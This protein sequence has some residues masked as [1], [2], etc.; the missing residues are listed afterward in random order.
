MAIALLNYLKN[1]S[2]ELFDDSS[3]KLYSNSSAKLYSDS[4]AKLYDNSYYL[5]EKT[6]YTKSEQYKLKQI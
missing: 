2:A 5:K 1:S 4:S 3:A 6:F